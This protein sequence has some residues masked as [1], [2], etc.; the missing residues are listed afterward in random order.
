MLKAWTLEGL[1]PP[2]GGQ[3]AYFQ[4]EANIGEI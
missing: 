2:G 1:L 3:L 4:G